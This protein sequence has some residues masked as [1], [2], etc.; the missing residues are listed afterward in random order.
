M[1]YRLLTEF[2]NLFSGK[3]YRHRVS[4][5]GDF[6]AIHLY[7]DLAA[8]GLSSKYLQR[9]QGHSRILSTTNL[10]QGINARRGDGT[11]GDPVP[12]T[13]IISDPTYQVARGKIANVEIG[14]ETKILAKAMIQQ[15]DRVIND[16]QKQVVHFQQGGGNPICVAIVGI[17]HA[18]IADGYEGDRVYRTDGKDRP[19]PLQ[20]ASQAEQRL[21]HAVAPLYD[22]FVVLRYS[23]TNIS[24]FPFRWANPSQTTADYGAA[25]VRIS[26]EYDRRF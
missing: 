2:E 5:H 15:I 22:E 11:F 17:N 19:H 8:L 24:P 20:E 12:S 9:I 26:R 23:A 16:L 14:V 18:P 4:T 21:R 3:V 25:L 1:P 10:R 7:E 6:V 13:R